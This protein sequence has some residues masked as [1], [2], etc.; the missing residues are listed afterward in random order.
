M[1]RWRRRQKPEQV[2]EAAPR[3]ALRRWLP[4][5]G[6]WLAVGVMWVIV[7]VALLA[8]GVLTS[9]GVRT[10]LLAAGLDLA[11]PALPGRVTVG[12]TQWPELGHLILQ[13]VVWDDAGAPPVVLA[14]LTRLDLRLDLRALRS[15]DARLD[16]LA[17]ELAA[18]DVP[19]IDV[20][21][22][23]REAAADSAAASAR[24]STASGGVLREGSLPGLPSLAVSYWRLAVKQAVL[25]ADLTLADLQG[26]GRLEAGWQH[27]PRLSVDHLEL[28][29]ASTAIATPNGEPW[30]I[31]LAHLGMGVSFTA[32]RDSLA[33]HELV[34]AT[35][36]SLALRFDSIGG[37][38]GDSTGGRTAAG[39]AVAWRTSEPVLMTNS[40]WVT[41]DHGN[42]RGELT[43][44]FALPGA[45]ELRSFL[46]ADFPHAEFGRLNGQLALT[47]SL[48]GR[49]A[50]LAADLDLADTS[51]L[52]SGRLR[53]RAAGN[54]DEILA[55]GLAAVSVD[56]DS[57][58]IGLRG[59]GIQA[60]GRLDHGSIDLGLSAAVADTQLAALFRPADVAGIDVDLALGVRLGG[61]LV[62]PTIAADLAGHLA[63]PQATV[64]RIALH[65]EASTM[66][67]SL[68]LDL[69]EG[70]A[71][72]TVT[73]DSAVV[74]IDAAR[75]AGDSLTAGFSLSVWQGADHLRFGGQAWAD[76]LGRAPLRRVRVDSLV[77]GAYGE[78]MRLQE[79]VEFAL[80]PA[81]GDVSLTSLVFA[82][83]PGEVGLGGRIAP[84]SQDLEARVALSLAEDLLMRIHPLDFW[85]DD[86][87]RDITLNAHV[88]LG[89]T[90]TEPSLDGGFSARLTPHRD[91]PE[92]GLDLTFALS[93]GDSAGVGADMALIVGDST[94]L[95]GRLD[96]PGRFAVDTGKWEHAVDRSA[97]I[98]VPDQT[99]GLAP[100]N[101]M[102]PPDVAV[103]GAL[104]FGADVVLPLGATADTAGA[105]DA[106]EPGSI[107]A[108][109]G[110]PDL[111]LSLPN[112]SRIQ[113]VVDLNAGG[114]VSAPSL[115]GRIVIESGYFRIPEL[116]RNLHPVDGAP[117]L[118]AMAAADTS[119]AR[120]DSSA[121]F[122]RPAVEGPAVRSRGPG[123]L[124]ELDLEIVVPGNLRIHGYG[125]DTELAGD[126][127]VER[128]FDEDGLPRPRIHGQIHTVEGS[129]QF[130][131]RVFNVDR[132][133]IRFTG[134][135]PADP[136]LDMVL[137][138]EVS[139]TLIRIEVVGTAS[140][141]QIVM[142]SEPE[143][144]QQ[145]IMAV[146]LFGRP[147]SELDN[148]QRGGVQ[149]GNDAGQQLRQNLAGLAMVFGTA[150]LQNSVSN[151]LGVDM[152][153]V[154]S[155]SSGE[156]TLMVG[157]FINPRLMLKYNQSL[158][159]SG[160]YFLT[161]E[162]TLSRIFKLVSTY[163]QGEEDSGLE[164]QWARRY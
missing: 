52:D 9:S 63:S 111:M 106:R 138:A 48:T 16:S 51:W 100:L 58:A 59:A 18:L 40:A 75:S 155:D 21:M 128:G 3:S 133:E 115:G 17:L 93:E 53:L 102:L 54:I 74:R 139:G 97:L 20:L 161:M 66:G 34:G 38:G 84:D 37:T 122:E 85:S 10:R 26:T 1:V 140:S 113:M 31:S 143:Y 87:G 130:M 6:H 151:T 2:P 154:G 95:G 35:L 43:T 123:F 92:L 19:A 164:L 15:G 45:Y 109:I 23:A 98:V 32:D 137:V 132:G 69:P 119:V 117:L 88:V 116:P 68:A 104:T 77:A 129:L 5:A 13:D 147:M 156:S 105:A 70:L 29:L 96:V 65:L 72:G 159:K 83:G 8:G 126:L 141:P 153:E 50:E 152:V 24:D 76:S 99:I 27:Q 61:T 101:R 144:E 118:W 55:D 149:G 12:A 25:T 103:I 158:E 135:V 22:R 124:P 14:R 163:G 131:N 57:V 82:G 160:T 125:L 121:V 134:D 80:G 110:A 49:R 86:G 94:V 127:K 136:D 162:Y 62:A 90:R 47:G 60:A 36:D 79:P 39:S 64:P 42:Y 108:R 114:T 7:A 41:R 46:P 157:K 91:D 150:G 146:L 120:A 73:V 33:R 112:R 145:D 30:T 148:D 67:T 44:V 4:R 78:E 142:S 107:R 56:L 71:T 89:G 11:A 28:D 81:V